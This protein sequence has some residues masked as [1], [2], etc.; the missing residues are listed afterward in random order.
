MD[1]D[2]YEASVY[3]NFDIEN[4]NKII[5]FLSDNGCDYINEILLNYLDL[6]LIKYDIFANKFNKLNIKYNNKLLEEVNN[7]MNILE[8]FYNI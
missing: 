3:K 1:F 5:E 8:E 7:D 2:K 4:M 6:F